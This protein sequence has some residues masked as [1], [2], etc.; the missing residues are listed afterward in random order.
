MMDVLAEVGVFL[1]NS[2]LFSLDGRVYKKKARVVT[3]VALRILNQSGA[4]L[5]GSIS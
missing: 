3:V 5:R 1:I 4:V 2:G